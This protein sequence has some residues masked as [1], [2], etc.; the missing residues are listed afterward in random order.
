MEAARREMVYE[1][2]LRLETRRIGGW[3]SL[4]MQASGLKER[5]IGRED[6]TSKGEKSKRIVA[7]K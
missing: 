7:L 4:D 2:P 1:A 6:E 3:F 5:M